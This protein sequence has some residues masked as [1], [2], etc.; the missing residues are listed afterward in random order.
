MV[1]CLSANFLYQNEKQL[2]FI[3]MKQIKTLFFTN[4][5]LNICAFLGYYVIIKYERTRLTTA[6]CTIAEAVHILHI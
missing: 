5:V 6:L 2:D 1:V 4:E 3:L